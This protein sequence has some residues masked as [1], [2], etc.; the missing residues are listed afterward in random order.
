MTVSIVKRPMSDSERE[1]LSST[2]K[3]SLDLSY[4]GA[5]AWGGAMLMF[6]YVFAWKFVAWIVRRVSGAEIGWDG[7]TAPWILA[8]GIAACALFIGREV[9]RAL[10]RARRGGQERR[11]ELA[12]GEVLEESYEFSEAR[13]FQ[14][15]EHGGMI[16]F[17]RSTGTGVFVVY[18]HESQDLGVEGRNPLDSSFR[19]S[20]VMQLVRS[21]VREFVISRRFSGPVLDPGDPRVLTLNPRYWPDPDT[22]WKHPWAELDKRLSSA[23]RKKARKGK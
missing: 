4:F 13:R 12:A 10:L 17:L 14:E 16:Y 20:A 2:G 19:P 6:V 9:T 18:D 21:P 23:R 1:F 11:R 22:W 7:P 3:G 15:P 5:L 8:A